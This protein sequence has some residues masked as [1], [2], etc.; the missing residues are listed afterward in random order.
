LPDTSER[1]IRYDLQ[2]LVEQSLVE[3]IG[4]AGPLVFYRAS[5][6]EQGASAE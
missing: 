2:T 6:V 5:R 1:T 3:R 4:N